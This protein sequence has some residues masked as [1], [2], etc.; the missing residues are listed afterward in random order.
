M[1]R[2]TKKSAMDTLI[3]IENKT[4]ETE[5]QTDMPI[6]A[7]PEA[8]EAVEPEAE[9]APMEA[10]PEAAPITPMAEIIS[11]LDELFAVLNKAYFEE[12]LP[13]P[14][15]TVQNTPKAYGH[16]TTR[17]VWSDGATKRYEINIDAGS[18]SRD[19][20]NI[21]A[22]MVHEMVHLYCAVN[23][24]KETCQNG[25]YHNKKFKDEAEARDIDIGY[26]YDVGFSLT[27]PTPELQATLEAA[28]CFHVINLNRDSRKVKDTGLNGRKRKTVNTWYCPI[29]GQEIHSSATDLNLI[30]GNDGAKF[31]MKVYEKRRHASAIAEEPVVEEPTPEVA[32]MP[33]AEEL[34]AESK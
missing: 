13:T 4:A 32:E 7:E 19:W 26:S 10:A 9:E 12:A 3:E 5:T 2:K 1:A 33:E 29:C 30:C 8:V 15:I 24:I 34:A 14:V 21:A 25:R 23:G 20:L 16:C 31:E 11:D 28:N 27:E 17:E 6:V 18:L 22:T